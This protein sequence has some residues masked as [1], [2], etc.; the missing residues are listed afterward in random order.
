[1]IQIYSDTCNITVWIRFSST[2]LDT[3]KLN[4]C[5]FLPVLVRI[6]YYFSDQI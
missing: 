5:E 2:S 3:K 6:R 4:P 1:M